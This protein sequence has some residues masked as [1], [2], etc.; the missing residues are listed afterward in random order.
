MRTVLLFILLALLASDATAVNYYFSTLTGDDSR[1]AQQAQ[2]PSTPWQSIDRLNAMA[3]SLKPGDSVLFRRGDT[4]YGT[5]VARTSG[6]AGNVIYYGAYGTGAAPVISGFTTVSSWTQ[7]T[8]PNIYYATVD[9]PNLS[10]VAINGEAR[11]RGRFP[12][13]GFS[14]LR[15]QYRQHQHHRQPA[16]VFA[17]LDGGRDRYAEVPLYSRPAYGY[18]SCR[19]KAELQPFYTQWQ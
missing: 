14:Q 18:L 1:T 7:H 3:T 15:K 16:G 9:M 11:G 4:F 19:H 17:Q 12:N 6:V 13:T 2:S 5:I 10:I 8:D